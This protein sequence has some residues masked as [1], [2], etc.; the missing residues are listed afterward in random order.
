MSSEN[1]RDVVG[2]EGIYMV[3]DLGNVKRLNYRNTGKEYILKPTDNGEGYMVVSL[4]K[5]GESKNLRVHRLVAEAFIPNPSNLPVINHKDENPANNRADNLEWCDVQYNTN[6]GSGLDKMLDRRMNKQSTNRPR[7]VVGISETD[8]SR[9]EFSSIADA[10][11]YFTGKA[12]GTNIS[13][14]VRGLRKT[15]FGFHWFYA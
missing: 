7:K 15:S 10:S 2:F 8:G 12:L 4:Y 13:A 5:N 3:S 9:I 1:W 6:Y 14:C 11:R